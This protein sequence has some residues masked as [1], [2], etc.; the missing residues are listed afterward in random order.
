VSFQ[1]CRTFVP[2]H[3]RIYH[4]NP[5]AG[6]EYTIHNTDLGGHPF[7]ISWISHK[8]VRRLVIECPE[9]AV[10]LI[11]G[12]AVSRKIPWPDGHRRPPHPLMM[13]NGVLC[14]GASTWLEASVIRTSRGLRSA[15]DSEWIL[16]VRV[17]VIKILI[18]YTTLVLKWV[19]WAYSHGELRTDV[20]GF[21]FTNS[22][23][24]MRFPQGSTITLT[25]LGTSI[26]L[27]GTFKERSW[28]SNSD[29]APD[30]RRFKYIALWWPIDARELFLTV[31]L[32]KPCIKS[33]K[34][35]I[36][37]TTASVKESCQF[38][39]HYTHSLF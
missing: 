19:R 36:R 4:P 10:L 21:L 13:W 26:V 6:I 12:I 22:F 7:N 23:W 5:F 16:R 15:M 34:P 39:E 31:P 14:L 3:R 27:C 17:G 37:R 25:Y 30:S 18:L 8:Y 9:L 35:I 11:A 28:N 29:L 1:V 32:D 20:V 24:L 38:W 33:N 2:I